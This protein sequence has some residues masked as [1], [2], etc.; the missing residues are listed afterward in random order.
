[1]LLRQPR[2]YLELSARVANVGGTGCETCRVAADTCHCERPGEAIGEGA[3]STAVE[4]QEL[5][6]SCRE[7]E[8][9]HHEESSGEAID[10]WAAQL[11]RRC[12]TLQMP[13]P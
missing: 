2:L 4:G 13:I 8:A 12:L 1:M 3:V 10:E 7:V 9:W 5:K 6:G 11:E